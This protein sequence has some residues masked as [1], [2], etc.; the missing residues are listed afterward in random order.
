MVDNKL[1]VVG[2][3]FLG[4]KFKKYNS[5]LKKKKLIIYV[6][7]V[8]NSNEKN[9]KNLKRDINKLYQFIKN[10]KKNKI[11]Y[12]SSC[13]IFDPNR[14]KSLYLRNKLKIEK[15]IKKNCN[16]YIII[17]LPE[18]VGKNK[19][20]YTLTNYFYNKI[21]NSLPFTLY[22]NS[23]RNILDVDDA[24][25]LIFHFL[26]KKTKLKYLN[27]ANIKFINPKK[28]IEIMEQIVNKKA[29]YIISKKKLINWSINNNVNSDLL[30]KTKIKIGKDYL[31]KILS[32]YYK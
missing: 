17:R 5:F 26:K 29:K 7:G 11:I 8:S 27:I 3:G 23:K 16:D 2:N 31:N 22:I 32:K 20:K 1:N 15:L 12:I 30:K 18:I 10:N 14:K 4:N 28:I 13:S 9:L 6:A 19:N 25:K 24:V 21:N